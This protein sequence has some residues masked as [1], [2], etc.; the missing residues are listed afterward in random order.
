MP[1]PHRASLR[2]HLLPQAREHTCACW[3]VLRVTSVCAPGPEKTGEGHD[4][5]E[6]EQQKQQHGI[7]RAHT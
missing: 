7:H 3:S 1:E 5:N 6:P 4:P 2:T